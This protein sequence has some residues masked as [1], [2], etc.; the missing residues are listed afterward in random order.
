MASEQQRLGDLL[1]VPREDLD[2]E[3]KNWLALADSDEHKATF[4][5][6]VIA[7]ANHG[8]GFIVIGL[9]QTSSG[10]VEAT[11][12]PLTLDAY[13][14]DLINGIVHNYCD[15]SMHCAVH[16][17]A[18]PGGASHPVVVVP[19]G[20][21]VPVRAKRAGPHGKIVENHA[22]YVRKPGPKS[23]VPLTSPEWD[24]LLNRCQIN[25]RDEM[26]DQIRDLISGAVPQALPH[27]EPER[28]P[29]WM[30]R[31]RERWVKLTE[32]LPA[33]VGP[34]MPHGRYC[35]GYEIF[36][37]PK[38]MTPAEFAELLR[39]STVRHSGWPPFWMPT[40]AGITPYYLDNA[41][42]CWLGG[43]TQTP[44]EDRD[45][46]HADFWRVSASGLAYLLRGYQEDD[47]ELRPGR[48]PYAPASAFDL[49]IPV[50]RVGETMLH[51]ESLA[52]HLFEG[53]TTIKFIAIYEGLANRSLVNLDGRRL[54]FDG[55]VARQ[56]TITLTTHVDAQAIGSNLPEI[57]HPFLEPLYALFDFFALPMSLVSEE[58]TRLRAG[59]T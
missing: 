21:R 36:G 5:K 8:G 51:A 31:S 17:V 48:T 58:L 42:E 19:G 12:R 33:K 57:V 41:I 16:L 22:M 2:C 28:L 32:S 1:V 15:P 34:R 20:H 3:I 45:A 55:R 54:L 14:Q 50:W 53:P 35:F 10:F 47:L 59:H 11:G 13:S 49:T 37:N 38:P 26:F 52:R 30:Q 6:A 56:D 4:A 44:P 18:A 25:R 39:A 23:E 7:L 29:D 43:D 24:A 27:P 40:R 46:A 9:E